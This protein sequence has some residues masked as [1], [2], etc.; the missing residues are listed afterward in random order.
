ILCYE[1][2]ARPLLKIVGTVCFARAV[3]VRY[4]F[5]WHLNT[6]PSTVPD[7]NSDGQK[8]I[9]PIL[10]VDGHAAKCDFTKALKTD[11]AYPTEETRDW[12]WYQPA[13]DEVTKGGVTLGGHYER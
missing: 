9:S 7:L 6:G 11:P 10:F 8:F 1:Q 4:Y 12:V 3:E 5:H 13:P 2:P